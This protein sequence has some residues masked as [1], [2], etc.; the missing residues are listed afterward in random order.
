MGRKPPAF[1]TDSVDPKGIAGP[2]SLVPAKPV[3]SV[4][5]EGKLL[6]FNF[7]FQF[8]LVVRL[9]TPSKRC[10]SAFPSVHTSLSHAEKPLCSSRRPHNWALFF[11]QDTDIRRTAASHF[12][13]R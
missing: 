10:F 6:P 1:L 3:T 4:L 11:F 9:H 12:L 13:A 7:L 8:F 2:P 5:C